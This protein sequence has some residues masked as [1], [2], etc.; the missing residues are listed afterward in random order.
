MEQALSREDGEQLEGERDS[1]NMIQTESDL[2]LA[3][4]EYLEEFG[5]ELDFL[6]DQ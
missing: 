4:E 6:P 2:E 1:P 5:N 3:Q